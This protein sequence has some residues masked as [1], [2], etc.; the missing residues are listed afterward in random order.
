MPPRRA[1]FLLFIIGRR[2]EKT[3]IIIREFDP[4]YNSE[5]VRK[6]PSIGCAS[7]TED[8]IGMIVGGDA[9]EN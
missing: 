1:V 9:S 6:F 8:L 2:D 4:T 7:Q 3:V 5:D